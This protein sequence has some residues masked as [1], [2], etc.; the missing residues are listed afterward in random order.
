VPRPGP[1]PLPAILSCA[2]L[3]GCNAPAPTATALPPTGGTLRVAIVANGT[4]VL[5]GSPYYDPGAFTFSPL[6]RCCLLRTLLSY[7]GR[8]IDEGGAEL[9]PDLAEALPLVSADGLTWTFKLRAGLRYAPPLADRTIEAR[10]FITA[11][12]HAIRFSDD[13]PFLEDIVGIPEFRDGSVDT[14]AG[15]EAPDPTRLVI[16]LVAPAGDLGNRVALAIMAPLPEEAFAG[17][18]HKDYAGFLVASGPY[19]YEGAERLDLSDTNAPP[20]WAG[21]EAGRVTLVRNPS[22]SRASD[23]LRPAHPERIETIMVADLDEGI[24]LIESGEADLLAEPAPESVAQR[25]LASDALRTRVF[26]QST[27]IVQYMS[28]NVAAPP[29]D[30]VHVRR[31]VNLVIDRANVAAALSEEGGRDVTVAHHAFP[32]MVENALLRTYDPYPSSGDG[33]DVAGA[34][35][36]MRQSA[37]D[38]DGDGRCDAAACSRVPAAANGQRLLALV[39]ADLA[40]IGIELMPT[41]AN[42]FLAQSHVA[43]F[44]G[45]GWGADFPNGSSFIA[46]LSQE[47]ISDTG[48]SNLSLVG[49]SAEQLASWDYEVNDVPSLERKVDSCRQAVGS[50]AFMCYAELDQL[51]M[52]RVVAWVPLGFVDHHWVFSERVAEFSPDA[53]SIAPSLDQIRLHPEG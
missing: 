53:D 17:R 25:Y 21:G 24:A 1:S 22:W 20:I 15:I 28:M 36:E 29:F 19:M 38:T 44:I 37:Y 49:A 30:D 48:L 35:E 16:H 52:E 43:T 4:E 42:A 6:N 18:K 33:G 47:G 39:M 5:P 41:E 46:L 23:P 2:L 26:S 14:I 50:A 31:A 9:R 3:L 13:V 11:A 51:V 8:P 10:D 32:D 40:K 7:N 12:E 45:I 34:R 27:R